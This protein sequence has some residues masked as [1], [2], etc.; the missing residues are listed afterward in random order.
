MPENLKKTDLRV[1]VQMICGHFR[2][3]T[4]FEW[5]RVQDLCQARLVLVPSASAS[6]I[7]SNQSSLTLFLAVGKVLTFTRAPNVKRNQQAHS[8]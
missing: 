4:S 6:R 1:F 5:F 8:V 3:E 7:S 2:V